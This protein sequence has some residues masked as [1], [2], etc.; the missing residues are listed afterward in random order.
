MSSRE[1]GFRG[2]SAVEN[3]G[4][5]AQRAPKEFA[6]AQTPEQFS[7]D[8]PIDWEELTL[9]VEVDVLGKRVRGTATWQGTVRKQELQRIRL[10]AEGFEV[11]RS[12]GG[13]GHRLTTEHDGRHLWI[14]LG[15]QRHRGDEVRISIDFDTKDPRAGFY[16]VLP[17]AD[18]PDRPAHAWT[19][20]Q[21]EDSKYWFP[22]HDSPNHK[23]RIHLIATVPEGMSAL[24]NGMLRNIYRAADP[25]KRTFD[26]QM[27]RPIPIY[28]LTL[29]VGP[30][31]EVVQ[32]EE[33]LPISYWVLPGRQEDGERSF[34]RTPEM[35]ALYE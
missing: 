33:P 22:C 24:S 6:T 4:L 11:L 13:D 28:L 10:D 2:I 20:G 17:D 8:V 32:R 35:V 12:F 1:H 30:F 31:V 29:V 27:A 9:S 14:D 18:H 21:D 23:A 25:T 34:G 5:Y 15:A 16:F 3:S 7:P 19:Q 26:W